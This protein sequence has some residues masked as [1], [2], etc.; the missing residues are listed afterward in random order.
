MD[1]GL[2]FIVHEFL[3]FMGYLFFNTMLKPYINYFSKT[4][5]SASAPNFANVSVISLTIGSGPQT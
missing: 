2:W 3:L 5:K 1:G 4:I